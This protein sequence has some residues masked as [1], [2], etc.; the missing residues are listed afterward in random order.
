MKRLE[1]DKAM[2]SVHPLMFWEKNEYINEYNKSLYFIGGRGTSFLF[3]TKQNFYLI[4][5]KHNLYGKTTNEIIKEM[6]TC[7]IPND[8]NKINE[9][10]NI[11]NFNKN[12]I[13]R[14]KYLPITVSEDYTDLHDLCIF[15]IFDN[16][17]DDSNC[18]SYQFPD[19]ST[20]DTGFMIGFPN[21]L[22]TESNNIIEYTKA[23]VPLEIAGISEK[24][25]LMIYGHNANIKD[26]NG[27]SGSPAV[28][29]N[30]D[31]NKYILMGM[32]ILAGTDT[33]SIIPASTINNIILEFEEKFMLNKSSYNKFSSENL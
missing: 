6:G 14:L 33:V 20:E 22:K 27:F 3:K 26:L 2:N 15:H 16:F 12:N 30:S 23:I 13:L 10:L 9:I 19:F 1:K 17:P 11:D 21:N 4:T 8:Y 5:A 28:Q 18:L 32:T 25:L 31:K 29:F 24:D 7:Y